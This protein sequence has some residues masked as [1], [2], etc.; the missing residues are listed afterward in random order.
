MTLSVVFARA[1]QVVPDQRRPGRSQRAGV[2]SQRQVPLSLRIHRRRPGARLVRAV[3]R[4]QPPHAQRLSGR[5]AQR[6][7]VAAGA[8]ES[9]EEKPCGRRPATAAAARCKRRTCSS[10]R[11]LRNRQPQRRRAGPHRF[12]GHRIPH[13]RSAGSRRAIS[14]TCRRATRITSTTCARTPIAPVTGGGRRR[15]AARTRCTGSISPSARTSR[16]STTCAT[17]ASRPTARSCCTRTATRG[18]SSPLH[19]RSRSI[20]PTGGSPS[21][22]SR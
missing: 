9:D 6:P 13:P 15:R 14:P 16:S 22:A 2:R 21:P 5:A 12:R 7:A 17:T 11:H 19:R 18:R 10:R 1:G 4:R 8:S 20:R 3:D